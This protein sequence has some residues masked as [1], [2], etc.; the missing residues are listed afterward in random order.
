MKTI[1]VQTISDNVKRFGVKVKLE[2]G[3][4]ACISL[5]LGEDQRFEPNTKVGVIVPVNGQLY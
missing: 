4:S 5:F 1:V 3:F 2:L